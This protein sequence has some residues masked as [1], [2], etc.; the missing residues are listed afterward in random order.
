MMVPK[1]PSVTDLHNLISILFESDV[2]NLY[3]LQYLDS[4]DGTF[5]TV[6]SQRELEEYTSSLPSDGV[7]QVEIGVC[8]GEKVGLLSAAQQL[9]RERENT[10]H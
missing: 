2:P 10:K 4:S 9:H 3:Y 1:W 7:F 5:V 8:E 6:A